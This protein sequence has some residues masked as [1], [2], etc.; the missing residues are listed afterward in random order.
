MGSHFGTSR[1]SFS[2]G[3]PPRY[4]FVLAAVVSSLL[5]IV[6]ILASASANWLQAVLAAI[7]FVVGA[8]VCIQ[9]GLLIRQGAARSGQKLIEWL[10]TEPEL[11]QQ[12]LNLEVA[13]LS[14][15]LEVEAEQISELQSA[16]VVAEDLALRQ[17]QQDD[18]AALIRHITIGKVPFDGIMVKNDVINC[19]DVSFLVVPDLRQ[20]KIAAMLKKIGRVKDTIVQSGSRMK[21]RLMMVLVTQLTPEDDEQLRKVLGK[22]RFEETPVDVD[23]RLL[24]F[25]SL[26]KIYVTE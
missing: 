26:Q 20:E 2:N 25:E 5:L 12:T 21:V 22:Q 6:A 14:R 3:G 8:A 19:I 16:Y 1:D 11:Q 15:I 24:D 10:N 9:I 23:I 4:L 18:D 17:I 7:G 13:E